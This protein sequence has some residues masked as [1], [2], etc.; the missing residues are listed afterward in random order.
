LEVVGEWIEESQDAVEQPQLLLESV[1]TAETIQAWL[2]ARLA[3][4]LNVSPDYI[5]IDEPFADY[6]LDS[7]V[8]VTLTGELADWL[9][10]DLSPTLFWKYPNISTLAQ[11][12][13]QEYQLAPSEIQLV[14]L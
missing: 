12:L 5:D 9:N 1:P 10:R 2:I 3:P 4:Y 7:S 6:G 14:S 13:A 8:A 11:H